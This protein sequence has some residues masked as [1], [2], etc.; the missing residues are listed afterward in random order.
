[1]L[2]PFSWTVMVSITFSHENIKMGLSQIWQDHL[3]VF[4]LN[5]QKKKVIESRKIDCWKNIV[6]D[7][8]NS[9]Q[10]S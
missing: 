2:Q 5:E 10:T 7:V 3:K 1:M 4:Q 8:D 6:S 9:S